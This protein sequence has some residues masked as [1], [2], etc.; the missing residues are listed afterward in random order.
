MGSEWRVEAC[1]NAFAD[2]E[3]H[4]GEPERE[5]EPL[6][7]PHRFTETEA[8]ECRDDRHSAEHQSDEADVDAVGRR[9]I[10]RAELEGER[11]GTNDGAVHRCTTARPRHPADRCQRRVEHPGH[12]EAQ[13][14][15]R[16]R[17]C[18]VQRDARRRVT[19]APQ[20]NECATQQAGRHAGDK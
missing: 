1:M 15:D 8:D 18:V 7:P 10:D 6:Q 19:G 12:A 20:Q 5:A 14:Q 17:R 9:Q 2:G 3:R 16:E 11:Q 4:S 13:H